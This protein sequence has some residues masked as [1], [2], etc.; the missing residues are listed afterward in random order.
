MQ[1]SES[2]SALYRSHVTVSPMAWSG[3]LCS[4]SAVLEPTLSPLFSSTRLYLLISYPLDKLWALS[5]F[6][7]DKW[8]GRVEKLVQG[9]SRRTLLVQGTEDQFTKHTV[10]LAVRK[11]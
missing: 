5:A 6:G 2:D 8:K 10:R 4:A 1:C 3:D 7:T 11:A 9:K